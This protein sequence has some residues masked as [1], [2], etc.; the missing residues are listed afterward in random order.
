[1]KTKSVSK[2]P[3]I[4][5]RWRDNDLRFLKAKVREVVLVEATTKRGQ[6]AFKCTVYLDGERGRDTIIRADRFKQ[7]KT[8]YTFVSEMEA[9]KP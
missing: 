9:P 8:G 7:I 4:G 5:Q 1:M 2:T 3:A 6:P